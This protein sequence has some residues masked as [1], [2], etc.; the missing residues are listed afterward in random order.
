LHNRKPRRFSFFGNKTGC[1]E[2]ERQLRATGLLP[3]N[4]P[5]NESQHFRPAGTRVALPGTN[6]RSSEIESGLQ[7]FFSQG[8]QVPILKPCVLHFSRSERKLR[9]EF[10]YAN[11]DEMALEILR[12]SL[13][14]LLRMTKT[15]ECSGPQT[16]RNHFANR[17]RY[18][19]LLQAVRKHLHG[20]GVISV[21]D[22]GQLLEFAHPFGRFGSEQVPLAGMHADQLAGAGDLKTLGGAAMGLQF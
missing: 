12:Q 1:G 8:L 15:R 19:Y 18:G 22:L 14:D 20:L 11:R 6:R 17:A 9:E 2:A 4:H 3:V 16:I 5:R 7:G 21:A 10:C 13:S